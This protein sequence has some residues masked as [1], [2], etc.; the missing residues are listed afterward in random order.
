MTDRLEPSVVSCDDA[1]PC[2]R[3]FSADRM[4]S[5]GR[6]L[7]T[8]FG[9]GRRV[10]GNVATPLILSLLIVAIA[11]V[12]PRSGTAQE[13]GTRYVLLI[14]GLGGEP[15]YTARF[16]EYLNQTRSAFVD[17]FGVPSDHVTVLAENRLVDQ[18]FV[19][20]V[21]TAENIRAAFETLAD[22]VTP[23]DHLYVV[24]FGHGSFDG[25]SAHL[26]IP[27][28]DLSD[29]DYA[30][31]LDDVDAGRSIVINTSSA[32]GPFAKRLSRPDRVVLAATATGT[33]RDETVFPRFFVEALRSSDADLDKSGGLSVLELFRYAAGEVARSFESAGRL[34]TEHAVIDDD[35]DGE[36]TRFDRLGTD[37]DGSLAAVTYIRPPDALATI[38]EAD[39]PLLRERQALQQEIAEIKRKKAEMRE[40]VYY[41][42][43]EN[44]LVR[45]AR[46][47]ERLDAGR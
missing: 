17:R 16:G 28:R 2:C 22:R 27:R 18:A 24:F 3:V 29:S 21:S 20:D 15:A 13:P 35:G 12:L 43:L 39:R 36:P 1:A 44:V 25:A 5:S 4:S 8:L 10:V 11:A 32:S 23:D 30:A 31:L 47:N 42:A 40:D 6:I 14:G 46:L 19:D 7:R 33:Q 34:A 37:T 26:N 45:L 41:D 38:S 9:S